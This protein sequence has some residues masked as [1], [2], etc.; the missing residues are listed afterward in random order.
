MNL[1]RPFVFEWN[2]QDGRCPCCGWKLTATEMIASPSGKMF[3]LVM[4]RNGKCA[5]RPQIRFAGDIPAAIE[6]LCKRYREENNH[7]N[8]EA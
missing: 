1:R 3:A 8:V 7:A 5:K 6:E 4:C 2:L